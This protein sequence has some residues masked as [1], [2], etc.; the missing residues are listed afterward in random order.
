[1]TTSSSQAALWLTAGVAASSV[2]VTLLITQ[3]RNSPETQGVEGKLEGLAEGGS[4]VKG[5]EV[6]LES[7]DRVVVKT[8]V[9]MLEEHTN[10][11]DHAKVHEEESDEAEFGY[12][13]EELEEEDEEE[14][15]TM[16]GSK[17]WKKVN[18]VW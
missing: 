6:M 14:G 3:A 7:S 1:M 16:S 10:S 13:N 8:G 2:A 5:E 17:F 9:S 11:N 15:R 18:Q 4:P 12:S